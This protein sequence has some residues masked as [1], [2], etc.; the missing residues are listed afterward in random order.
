[1]MENNPPP[2]W[3]RTRSELLEIDKDELI[4]SIR[5]LAIRLSV[6]KEEIERLK[7]EI[8]DLND[9]ITRVMR[10]FITNGKLD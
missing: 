2:L 7:Q 8:K 4:D 5:I 1:M 3:E 6:A 10:S 9:P